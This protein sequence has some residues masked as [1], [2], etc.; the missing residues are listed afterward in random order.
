MEW[1]IV[2]SMF[3]TIFLTILSMTSCVAVYK[4]GWKEYI[5]QWKSILLIRK[6]LTSCY[7]IE[8]KQNLNYIYP[9]GKVKTVA[10]EVLDYYYPVFK[11]GNVVIVECAVQ[12]KVVNSLKFSPYIKIYVIFNRK[13]DGK[14]VENTTELTS[15]CPWQQLFIN[16]IKK[17]L[18][19]LRIN[20]IKL[21]SLNKLEDVIYS[22]LLE[23][24]RDS[25]IN[26]ILND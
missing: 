3:T 21:E 18:I 11:N 16:S 13:V 25:K 15:Q 1:L 7:Q 22:N 20:S 14:W 8:K 10:S 4:L 17:K 24:D 6:G 5:N 2:F 26:L 12:Q 19:K 9:N 23:R